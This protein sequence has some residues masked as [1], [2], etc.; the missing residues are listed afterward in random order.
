MP[1]DFSFTHS[2]GQGIS[3]VVSSF[4]DRNL[5]LI[6]NLEK[7]GH[8][9]D[10]LFPRTAVPVQRNGAPEFETR[11][12]FGPDTGIYDLLISRLAR[13][14]CSL[15]L[16]QKPVR[17]LLGLDWTGQDEV[18][19]LSEV[20]DAVKTG[21]TRKSAFPVTVK[22]TERSR[23]DSELAQS[24]QYNEL[25]SWQK[26]LK[27]DEFVLLDGPPYS[28]GSLHVGHAVNKIL[29]DFIVKSRVLLGQTVDF[30]P[31]WDCHGLPIELAVRKNSNEKEASR[32]RE[33]AQQHA[34]NVINEHK[35][36]FK[37]WG[38][39]ADWNNPYCTYDSSYMANQ[40]RI[41]GKIY[42]KGYVYREF[43]PVFWSPSSQSALAESELEYNDMHVSKAVYF[44]FPVINFDISAVGVTRWKR[45]EPPLISAMIWTTTPWTL[46]LNDAISYNRELQYSLIQFKDNEKEPVEHYFLVCHDRLEFIQE[47]LQRPFNLISTFNGGVFKDIYYRSIMHNEL[48][49]PF[50]HGDHVSSTMGTGLVH[51]SFAHGFDDY[52]LGLSTNSRVRSFVD[53]NGRYTRDLGTRLEGKHVL[54]EGQDEV[55]NMFKKNILRQED[56]THSYPYD[57][58]TN[59]PVIIRSTRQWFI[60][61]SEVGLRCVEQINKKNIPFHA[62]NHDLRATMTSFLLSRPDWCISRQRVWGVPI[63]ALLDIHGSNHHTSAAFIHAVAD[64]IH[65]DYNWYWNATEKQLVE[66]LGNRDTNPE[67]VKKSTDIMD[68]WFDSGLV[69]HTLNGRVADVILEGRDQ[70]RG[71]FTSLLLTS[72]IAED[73]I[74]YKQVVVHGFTVDDNNKKM[75]KSK[76]NVI[77]PTTITDGSLKSPAIGVDGLRLWVALYGSENPGDVR[78]GQSVLEDV[79]LRLKQV[80]L[81]FRFILGAL[82]GY[83]GD[84][85]TR[86]N[87]LDQYILKETGRLEKKIHLLY[88]D[89]EFRHGTNET[90]QFL[91]SPF[92]S[93]YINLVK[94]RL[95]CDR[96]GSSSH[97]AVQYTLNAV[98]N[99]FI[100]ILSPIMPHL[101]SEYCSHHPLLKS[102]LSSSYRELLL[103][104]EQDDY[105][106]EPQ[107]DEIIK[108]TQNLRKKITETE[109]AKKEYV[110]KFA[111][112]DEELLSNVQKETFSVDSELVE[113]LGVGSVLLEGSGV[114]ELSEISGNLYVC[115]RCR[116]RNSEDGDRLCKRCSV[117]LGI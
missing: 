65:D 24:S 92:S 2:N 111:K 83:N 35:S 78:I 9:V 108:L 13:V 29:K 30:R 28:N 69:W 93:T 63:P 31:G 100:R 17:F 20:V 4:E 82:E 34:T 99:T 77:N 36:T 25:Y 21:L 114:T 104:G 60:D 58:R 42:D 40:L 26:D 95:Y 64:Q 54:K 32:I 70:F 47:Q 39:T 10:L 3:I 89:F 15:R 88:R 112:R 102:N 113:L 52:K 97:K 38:I 6:S 90:L 74:P 75:S 67:D 101:V 56:L 44:S 86:L 96:I 49:L 22:P 27:R 16:D 5:F 84:T 79:K 72:M 12:L 23:L 80:R 50:Y 115:K 1:G 57:W 59:Q 85:P 98:G 91:R 109:P 37:K 46:P 68:V 55:L 8:V 76:G 14:F 43:K 45:R 33:L 81:S 62:G 103:R 73:R 116:K 66:L 7:I 53:S 106:Y 87:Y 94:D 41:F 105:I 117:V 11:N 19:F 61:V 110:L 18:A 107:L 51:T 48:A 71:W